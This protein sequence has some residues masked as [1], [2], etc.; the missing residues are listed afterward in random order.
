MGY[1]FKKPIIS[2]TCTHGVMDVSVNTYYFIKVVLLFI[3]KEKNI[4]TY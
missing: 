3:T 1:S 2:S 4:C